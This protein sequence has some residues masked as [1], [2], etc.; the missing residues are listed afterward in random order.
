MKKP[1][2]TKQKLT[3]QDVEIWK[4]VSDTAVPL[5][6]K[7]NN[8]S[9]Y[10]PDREMFG[11]MLGE[12][13]RSDQV[14][15]LRTTTAPTYQP[16]AMPTLNNATVSMDLNTT[17]KIHK[18]KLAINGRID[19]HGLTQD[20]AWQA[21]YMRIENAYYSRQKILLVI[22][23]K[24]D[25]GRGVLRENV[26]QWLA[27]PPFNLMVSEFGTSHASHGGSGALYVRIR[28]KPQA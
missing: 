1:R 25:R 12:G 16:T 19:L 5:I 28:R 3:P 20:E 14:K 6:G 10:L 24:G 26:P 13:N 17:R 2:K 4:R 15:Q 22:T 9:G 21:L 11:H 8:Y 23:G 27:G 18:G 7:S